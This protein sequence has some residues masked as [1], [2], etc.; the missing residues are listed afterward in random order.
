MKVII[1]LLLFAVSVQALSAKETK[2][3]YIGAVSINPCQEAKI[4][5]DWYSK[6]GI[7][8]EAAGGGFYGSFETPAG[9]FYF[10]IHKKHLDSPKTSSQSVSIVFRVGN[11]DRSVAEAAQ[12]GVHPVSTE[13]DSEGRFAHYQDP[14]GNEVTL[15]GI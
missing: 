2:P 9:P 10:G 4:L 14:D 5:A 8:T 13:K 11:F 12:Q 15:W 3:Q 6:L 1:G 7:E